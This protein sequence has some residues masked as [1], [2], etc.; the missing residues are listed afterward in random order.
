MVADYK[1]LMHFTNNIWEFENTHKYAD[2]KLLADRIA[3]LYDVVE[4]NTYA[5]ISFDGEITTWDI[6]NSWS[7]SSASYKAHTFH[8]YS[9]PSFSLSKTQLSVGY[10][11]EENTV[12][13][14]ST[15]DIDI[16]CD[17]SWIKYAKTTHN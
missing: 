5:K 9:T 3:L 6:P 1:L 11:A 13:C 15:K 10:N 14:T 12:I 16:T 4:M 8:A 2:Y 7:S 17:A